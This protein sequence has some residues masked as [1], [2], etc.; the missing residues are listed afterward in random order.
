MTGA[1]Q[2]TDTMDTSGSPLNT[3][4]NL[5]QARPGRE[6]DDD[7]RTIVPESSYRDLEGG[8]GEGSARTKDTTRTRTRRLLIH[9]EEV[10]YPV[11]VPEDW[12]QAKLAERIPLH[13]GVHP[14]WMQLTWTDHHSVS[15]I[16]WDRSPRLTQGMRNDLL[17]ITRNL[18]PTRTERARFQQ[19]DLYL[20]HRSSRA[21]GLMATTAHYRDTT[22]RLN[23]LLKRL[24]PD[25][26]W[27]AIGLISHRDIPDHKD[28][29]AADWSTAITLTTKG[30]VFRYTSPLNGQMRNLALNKAIAVFDPTLPHGLTAGGQTQTLALYNTKRAP[31][32]Q[33]R[34][35][36]IALGFPVT[37]ETTRTPAPHALTPTPDFHR[38]RDRT[39]SPSRPSLEIGT[40]SSRRPLSF[41]GTP[42]VR[43]ITM[44]QSNQE[45]H[46]QQE[47]SS[48]S[49]PSRQASSSTSTTSGH[50]YDMATTPTWET[51][52][53]SETSPITPTVLESLEYIPFAEPWWSD[54]SEE[55]FDKAV[56]YGALNICG[57]AKAGEELKQHQADIGRALQAARQATVR[58]SKKQLVVIFKVEQRTLRR[59]LQ[60]EASPEGRKKLEQ[61]L[62]AA[63][64]RLT[65]PLQDSIV[66]P[67]KDHNNNLSD[68]AT[69]QP[70]RTS[71][72]PRGRTAA[73]KPPNGLSHTPDAEDRNSGTHQHQSTK[74][75]G[76]GI[77]GEPMREV[78]RSYS[79]EPS[80][81]T[82]PTSQLLDDLSN[83]DPDSDAIHMVST[84]ALA[85]QALYKAANGKGKVALIAPQRWD[86]STTTPV[87]ETMATIQTRTTVR[88]GREQ[89]TTSS[90]SSVPTW[91]YN[92]TPQVAVKAAIRP[93]I[94]LQGDRTTST[95]LRIRFST[96]SLPE[97]VR[98]LPLQDLC[99][100]EIPRRIGPNLLMDTWA[101]KEDEHG[102]V[103]ALLRIMTD[104]KAP[105]MRRSGF[106]DFWRDTPRQDLQAHQ[107]LWLSKPQEPITLQAARTL[108]KQAENHAGMIMKRQTHA[109]S[110]AL[111]ILPEHF[112]TTQT[113][114]KF[115][116]AQ[117][118]AVEGVPPNLGQSDLQEI[119]TKMGWQKVRIAGT[120]EWKR[121][122]AGWRVAAED[123]PPPT[124]VSKYRWATSATGSEYSHSESHSRTGRLY[125]RRAPQPPKPGPRRSREHEPKDLLSGRLTTTLALGRTTDL[126]APL[127]TPQERRREPRNQRRPERHRTGRR[128]PSLNHR[129][130]G[131][132]RTSLIPL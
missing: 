58:L 31:T 45:E 131:L 130:L 101:A 38:T 3:L 42:A 118:Y 109:V 129:Y 33:N 92:V 61:I 124:S 71:P 25:T 84:R 94:S 116:V 35:S 30:A 87:I 73:E 51:D 24:L 63:A 9:Y 12:A 106:E 22:Y 89:V 8:G 81:W 4:R 98:N 65:L 59:T 111:R 77:R 100:Q 90:R 44:D 95:I 15:L 16:L 17:D 20:G 79:L 7:V 117:N 2:P 97:A 121:G 41:P 39:R 105:L 19:K 13:F 53:T 123:P 86:L 76:S 56:Y 5:P 128:R 47:L 115:D 67:T 34:A 6:H 40:L 57:G 46:D 18:I 28:S 1:P 55:R 99:K 125:H 120:R 96:Q 11:Y 27:N 93:V 60:A 122:R 83:L 49:Q 80:E 107:P 104:H 75:K 72:K 64:R 52:I 127:A 108:A 29:L 14:E 91:I 85:E 126:R 69:A 21:H 74:G 119:L 37:S 110:Y 23:T 113:L 82:Y 48:D 88:Q 50:G 70:H 36:L 62:C 78:Q 66:S 102:D 26:A 103:S 32:A 114:L 10:Q 132:T 43:P 112:Q 68:Q 54:S